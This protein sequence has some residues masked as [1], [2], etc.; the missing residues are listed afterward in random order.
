[1]TMVNL[2]RR[3]VQD[4]TAQDFTEFTLLLAFVVV[5]AVAIFQV[6]T[7]NVTSIW[8]TTNHNLELGAQASS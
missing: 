4:Q 2:W 5:V 1:M 7:G 3:F 6:A 8:N